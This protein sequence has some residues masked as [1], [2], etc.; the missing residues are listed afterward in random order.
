MFVVSLCS[1]IA[2][3]IWVILVINESPADES[4]GEHDGDM[5]AASVS[6]ASTEPATKPIADGDV[7]FSVNHDEALIPPVSTRVFTRLSHNLRIF[8]KKFKEIFDMTNVKELFET[9]TKNRADSGRA[10]IWILFMCTAFILLS[11]LNTTFVLWGYVEKLYSWPPKFYSNVTSAV[12]I[13]TLLLMGLLLPVLVGALKFGDINLSL[14]GTL[15]LMAQCLLRGSWQHEAGLYFSFIFGT[16]APLSLIGLR[17]RLSKII[18]VCEQGKLF[19]LLAIVEA[20]TPGIASIF[21]SL[22]F[23]TSIDVYPGLSFQVAAFILLIP[24]LSTI[25][26][27]VYCVHDYDQPV[28]LH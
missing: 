1:Y 11:Y 25:F 7:F 21:Y 2:A 18:E 24:F 27:D 5:A 17:S 16:L 28:V 8:C 23:A 20:I 4:N 13:S 26:I 10:Q 22:I 6:D 19:A 14:L 15:S 12:A 3:I 9:L